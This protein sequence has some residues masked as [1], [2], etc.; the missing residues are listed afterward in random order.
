MPLSHL[1]SCACDIEYLVLL[2]EPRPWVAKQMDLGMAIG[3]ATMAA[4]A[5]SPGHMEDTAIDTLQTLSIR[6]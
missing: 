5:G 2:R 3:T 1:H 6:A 4:T